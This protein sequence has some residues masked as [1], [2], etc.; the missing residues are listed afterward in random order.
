[1]K[2]LRNK[3]V[4]TLVKKISLWNRTRKWMKFMSLFDADKHPKIL[5]VG[6]TNSNGS[7]MICTNFLERHYP[8]LEDVTALGVESNDQFSSLF[9][10]VNAIRYDGNEFPFLADSFD[11]VFSNAVI[12]HVGG[13]KNKRSLLKRCCA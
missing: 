12:E 7:G 5:D 11:I 8:Y 4:N 1:M 2:G 13:E 6:Y 9:P 10:Q 3:V